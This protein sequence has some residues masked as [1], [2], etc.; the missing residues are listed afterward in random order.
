MLQTV[1]LIG[2]YPQDPNLP[3]TLY[4]NEDGSLTKEIKD[5]RRVP[6]NR[7]HKALRE[8]KGYSNKFFVKPVADI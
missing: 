7:L 8:I 6:D 1:N 2:I 5:A 3:G 4:L